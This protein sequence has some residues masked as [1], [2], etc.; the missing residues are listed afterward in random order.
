MLKQTFYG[1]LGTLLCATAAQAAG[2]VVVLG[3]TET[4]EVII[5]GN[6]ADGTEAETALRDAKAMR[7]DGWTTL[8]GD[9]EP[10]WGAVVCVKYDQGVYFSQVNGQKSEADAIEGAKFGADRFIK[11]NGGGT[12]IPLCA[13]HWYN[14]GQQIAF[15]GPADLKSVSDDAVD[16]V[17][18]NVRKV[19]TNTD[20]DYKRDCVRP[21]SAPSAEAKLRPIGNGV[22]PRDVA[23]P[24][25]KSTSSEWKPA[26][27]CPKKPTMVSVGVRG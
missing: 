17:K 2:V 13:P 3:N 25:K 24:K 20:R 16:Y 4:G 10:G 11:E 19:T 22:I 14:R 15:G 9:D 12:I 18:G 1:V 8:F 7:K 26:S 6:F 5:R 21:E 23:E 27:W